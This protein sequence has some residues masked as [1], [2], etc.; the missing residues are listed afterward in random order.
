MA[1]MLNLS[2]KI[3][4]HGTRLVHIKPAAH[5][6]CFPAELFAF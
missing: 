4:V 3:K 5:D 2:L 1:F 6:A